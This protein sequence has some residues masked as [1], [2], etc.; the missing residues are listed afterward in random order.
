[1]S[2][3]I[4]V[5]GSAEL[6]VA[7]ELAVV[8]LTVGHSGPHRD[9]VLQEAG[10]AHQELIAEIRALEASGA[11]ELWSAGQLRVWSQRPWNAEGRRLPLVHEARADVE[12]VFRD[13]D[14]LGEW[15]SAAALRE[16]VT[17]T[18]IEWRL[19]DTTRRRLLEDA[20][21]AA[22]A[23][24]ITKAAVY[25]SALGLGRPSPIDLADHGMLTPPQ[26]PPQPKAMMMRAAAFGGA[27]P[28]VTELAPAD[29]LIEA[30][31]DARFTADAA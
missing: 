14:R 8:S 16:Q 9:G 19:T 30:S 17:V 6:R 11:L 23:D 31:V 15:V 18:G 12:A 10:A 5:T 27:E 2:T 28:P 26:R 13:L 20:Q 22:V 7:P 25:A 3:Q 29:L 21:R 24:A 1:M 4:T